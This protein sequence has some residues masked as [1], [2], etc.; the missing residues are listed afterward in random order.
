MKS[1]LLSL[2]LIVSTTTY[3]QWSMAPCGTW[4]AKPD[5]YSD[6]VPVDTIKVGRIIDT[7]R[8]WVYSEEKGLG[9]PNMTHANYCPCGCYEDKSYEQYRVCSIT[10]IRQRRYRTTS[11][12]YTPREATEYEKTI[13]KLKQN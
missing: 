1:L 11:W 5:V 8:T 2:T 13:E 3:G 6:W 12:Y 9:D 7:L 10:G 4:T